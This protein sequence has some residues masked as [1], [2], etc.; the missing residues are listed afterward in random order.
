MIEIMRGI[1]PN[2]QQFILEKAREYA[3][4][5]EKTVAVMLGRTQRLIDVLTALISLQITYIPIDPQLPDSRVAEILADSR[6]DF[7]I[8][9]PDAVERVSGF[10]ALSIPVGM[11][12]CS[13]RKPFRFSDASEDYIVY[14]L[15]TSGSTGKPKGV[16]V[17]KSSL[18]NLS[19]GWYRLFSQYS[20]IICLASL[21]FDMF[22]SETILPLFHDYRVF[23]GNEVEMNNPRLLEKEIANTPADIIQFTPSRLRQLLALDKELTCLGH[24][25]ALFLAGEN[26]HS[27]LLDLV[28][29]K[30]SCKI[31]NLYGPT[32]TTIYATCSDLTEKDEV[33]IGKP[34]DHYLIDIVDDS[35][36]PLKEGQIG[37]L[38]ISGIS[39]AD[40]Y[41]NQEELTAQVFR[42]ELLYENMVSYFTGDLGY[43]KTNGE[44][45]Y[46]G[47]KDHQVK[48]RGFRIELEE[49]ERKAEMVPGITAA[50]CVVY[51]KRILV[52]CYT[53]EN[54]IEEECLRTYLQ[55]VLPSYMVPSF[56]VY[57][58]VF[59][60]TVT[61]KVDR[62]QVEQSVIRRLDGAGDRMEY[63]LF[64]D[65]ISQKVLSIVSEQIEQPV[66]EE[67]CNTPL[68]ELR[69][70]SILYIELIVAL[71]EKFEI[72]FDEDDLMDG[73]QK[74][75]LT[76][77]QQ[78]KEILGDVGSNER[79]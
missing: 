12:C 75:I 17:K 6:P 69:I 50:I 29:E 70:D 67:L 56:L 44:I 73:G 65:E 24:I 68:I 72:E 15:Y 60:H 10:P 78:V 16:K 39:V 9:E 76:I 74:D 20:S 1:N 49:I 26:F 61:G 22:F 42:K 25:K 18:Q 66:T 31:Y 35:F 59:E 36:R 4:E 58:P 52:L 48:L 57:L 55:E 23:L 54:P 34:F 2:I 63:K 27:P 40:G 77:I 19:A 53:A 3:P 43:R 71:E 64:E 5:H 13:T 41:L 62:R 46:V 33:D 8:T 21:S 51:Q 30:L 11:D 14:V 79:N 47:R 7:V 38:V 32:E 45:H 37:E 28:R